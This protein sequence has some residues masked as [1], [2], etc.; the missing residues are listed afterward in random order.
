MLSSLVKSVM[1]LFPFGDKRLSVKLVRNKSQNLIKSKQFVKKKPRK[2]TAAKKP[3][4]KNPRILTNQTPV[5]GS[6][7][8]SHPVNDNQ[9]PSRR[10]IKKLVVELHK[11]VADILQQQT[12]NTT[13]SDLRDADDAVVTGDTNKPPQVA[14]QAPPPF[15][16]SHHES[17]NKHMKQGATGSTYRPG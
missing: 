13:S 10:Q 2:L 6:P 5:R 3:P 17:T 12:G 9:K 16:G 11:T 8:T 14:E 15:Q 7:A 4:P 1:S